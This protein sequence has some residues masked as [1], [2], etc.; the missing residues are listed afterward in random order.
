MEGMTPIW[1]YKY[2]MNFTLPAR[3][4]YTSEICTNYHTSNLIAVYSLFHRHTNY[5][6][7]YQ[8]YNCI[9]IL[10]RPDAGLQ[11]GERKPGARAGAVEA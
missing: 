8:P 5:H 2:K 10:H 4:D 7:Y 6:A 3:K 11:E 9:I 1:G